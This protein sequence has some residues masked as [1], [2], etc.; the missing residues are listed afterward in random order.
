MKI[1]I[2]A[3]IPKLAIDRKLLEK[4]RNKELKETKDDYEKT[5]DTWSDKPEFYSRRYGNADAT[6]GYVG[7]DHEIYHYIDLGTAHRHARMDDDFIRK[8]NPRSLTSGRGGEGG[9]RFVNKNYEGISPDTGLPGITAR[10]FTKKIA[11][12]HRISF[13]ERINAIAGKIIIVKSVT[14][15][16]A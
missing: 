13:R 16:D 15:I 10:D 2:R 3:K 14:T 7:Y 6:G 5:C 1:R 9:V 4:V 12:K 8:T 11:S